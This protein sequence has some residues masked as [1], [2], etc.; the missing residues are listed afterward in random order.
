[1]KIVQEVHK[2]KVPKIKIKSQK[3][4]LTTNTCTSCQ[5]AP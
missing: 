5:S 1:M 4:Q 2:R 3:V